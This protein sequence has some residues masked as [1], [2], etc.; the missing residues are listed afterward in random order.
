[1]QRKIIIKIL[2]I[3]FHSFNFWRKKLTII[4]V[5]RK[6]IDDNLLKID[7]N[8]CLKTRAT[9]RRLINVEKIDVEKQFVYHNCDGVVPDNHRVCVFADVAAET[10]PRPNFALNQR[11]FWYAKRHLKSP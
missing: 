2:L 3:L 9:V 6:E 7:G 5:E 11:Q 4:F 1:M 10:K 8:L